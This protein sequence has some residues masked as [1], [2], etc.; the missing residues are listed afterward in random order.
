MT[1]P[2]DRSR[3]R[4]AALAVTL[5][6]CSPDPA[7]AR[8]PTPSA[9]Q[10]APPAP[11]LVTAAVAAEPTTWPAPRFDAARPAAPLDD[12]RLAAVRDARARGAHLEAARLLEEVLSRA[13]GLDEEARAR[14]VLL[15]A[16]LRRDGGDP[17]G[18]IAAYERV[19]AISP[20]LAPAAAIEIAALA[21][22]SGKHAAALRVLE[23]VASAD[24][25]DPRFASLHAEALIRAGDA[26][27]GAETLEAWIDRTPRPPG[28]AKAALRVLGA[29]TAR[30]G[31]ARALA[32]A[33]VARKVLGAAH[34]SSAAEAHALAQ[35]ALDTLPRDARASA[36]GGPLGSRTDAARAKLRAREPRAAVAALDRLA[37]DPAARDRSLAS[38]ELWR[39]R[40]EALGEVKR[41]AEA[42]EAYGV[43]IDLCRGG[44]G[45][46]EVLFAAA[47]A[48]ASAQRHEEA[49]VRF[50]RVES[51]HPTSRLADDARVERVRAMLEL[52]DRA[53]ARAMA[54]EAMTSLAAGDVIGDAP[55]HVVLADALEGHW[56][57]TIPLLE[58]A[59]A[60]THERSYLRAGRFDYFL[61]RARGALGD[62]AAARTAYEAV[63]LGAPVGYYAALAH[64]RLEE[65]APGAGGQALAAAAAR[66]RASRPMPDPTDAEL[67]S[68]AL[69]RAAVLAAVGDGVAAEAQ[70]DGLGLAARTASPGLRWA[71]AQLLGRADGVRAHAVLRGA[72][73]TEARPAIVELDA[74]LSA[75]PV[76]PARGA[77]ELAFP[78]PWVE[79]VTRASR[80]AGTPAPLLYAIMREESAFAPTALSRAGAR[81][82]L[83][84]MP[85]TAAKM[86]RP[87]GLPHDDESLQEPEVNTRL[88]ARF[89]AHLRARFAHAP[90]LAVPA[91]NAGPLAVDR[92]CAERPDLDFDLWVETI[93][94]RETRLYTKR[95]LGSLAAYEVL[96]GAPGRSEVF[97]T[98]RRACPVVVE[99]SRHGSVEEAPPP[100][101]GP[102]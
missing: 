11:S 68:P 42:A 89:L 59:R 97:L 23:G 32:A 86:A 49:R 29:L 28:W 53:G 30:P 67:A 57:D 75:W 88:G 72:T 81:G 92:W 10:I 26:E 74:W 48:S 94:Y 60:A 90:L 99:A 87:L 21:L 24:R 13:T 15:G 19:V 18:A 40:G 8:V 55:F 71:A 3:G 44:D 101:A 31:E 43:A 79:E 54:L 1:R 73:E 78:R 61:G 16:V 95:V 80:E 47:K 77:W 7:P 66:G 5:V 50:A 4:L 36:A 20:L 85:P 6:A 33:R 63:L 12:P 35:R 2:R 64:A 100:E 96:A 58:R 45:A 22:Q 14:W 51:E 34:G 56:V 41:R 39:L 82:L 38:C 83:Q 9:A 102:P 37:R 25:A 91:Y 69:A 62:R 76:A 98:P 93:P 27:R 52:G 46:V 70:L 65:I 84:L 17:A